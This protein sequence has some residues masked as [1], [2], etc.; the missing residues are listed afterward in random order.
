MSP[1]VKKFPWYKE[2]WVWFFLSILGLGVVAGTSMLIIGLSNPPEMVVGDYARFAR[3]LVDTNQ[4]AARAKALGL[5]GQ[6]LISA[7]T[8]VVELSHSSDEPLP[9][10]L[11]VLFQHPAT[12]EE[13]ITIRL[14]NV[15]EGRYQGE[16]PQL[17]NPRA[18]AIVFDL[19]QTWWLSTPENSL[20]DLGSLTLFPHR[21]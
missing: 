3:G 6:L 15:D 1:I 14:I 11:L 17:P 7:Q 9:R 13:D 2:L 20:L 5:E 10:T 8:L 16:L 18:R 21:L 19:A 12:S 4:R